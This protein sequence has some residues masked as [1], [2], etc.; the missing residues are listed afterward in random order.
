MSA[1]VRA[2]EFPPRPGTVGNWLLKM[3]NPLTHSHCGGS[4]EVAL[5]ALL[6]PWL[7]P[8]W[9]EFWPCRGNT[10]IGQVFSQQAEKGVVMKT[11][12]A[13]LWQ[14]EAGFVISTELIFIATIV[15]I[16][17]I[18]GLATVRDQV[19]TELADV[20]DAVSELDQSFS[21]SA[22]T[23]TVGS[24]AGS[25]FNDQPDFCE[26][27]GAGADQNGAAGTQCL[28]ITGSV[29]TAE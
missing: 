15:V 7:S 29:G 12:W 20:A 27:A 28:V 23:A 16:G 25:T 2:R 22:I 4:T 21:Y 14:D 24:V 1:C 9:D 26:Q 10:V 3:G 8:L 11:R 5:V 17:M 18:T 19:V 13:Q 6:S